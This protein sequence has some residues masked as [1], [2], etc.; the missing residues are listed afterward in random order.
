MLSSK[1]LK[2]KIAYGILVGQTDNWGTVWQIDN[3]QK[4]L[5]FQS[6]CCNCTNC[7][8]GDFLFFE[9]EEDGEA[10]IAEMKEAQSAQ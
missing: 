8:T 6:C 5:I 10:F 9:T 2:G 7:K 1:A 3:A 4:T